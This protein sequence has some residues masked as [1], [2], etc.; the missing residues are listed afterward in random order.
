MDPGEDVQF[1]SDDD[2]QVRESI[3]VPRRRVL[4]SREQFLADRSCASSVD[5]D[6]LRADLDAV[7]DND[8]LDPYER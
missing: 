8:V 7:I 1:S 3:Q 2:Q 4:I 6:R 5:P